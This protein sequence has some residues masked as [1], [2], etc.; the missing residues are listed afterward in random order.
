M[1]PN[2]RLGLACLV[3]VTAV[4]GVRADGPG[5]IFPNE[6]QPNSYSKWWT[7]APRA[8]RVHAYCHGPKIPVY[9]P[10]RHPEVDAG[11]TIL[12]FPCPQAPADATFIERP[13]PP[14]ESKFKY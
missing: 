2:S 8:E 13:A 9:P 14:A 6:S 12:K 10:D 3:L 5:W 7:W 1:F 4:A 11:M